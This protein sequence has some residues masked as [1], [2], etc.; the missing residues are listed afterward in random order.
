MIALFS[1]ALALAGA[2]ATQDAEQAEQTDAERRV[3]VVQVQQLYESYPGTERFNQQVQAIQQEFAQAQQAE[4]TDAE[5]RVGVVQVQQ[6]YESYPGTERF[7]Q[8]VQAIQQEFAQAQQAGDQ[9][10]LQELQ[11]RYAQL[12]QE[13]SANFQS[14][15]REASRTLAQERQ[16]KLIVSEVI[17]QDDG[18][19][20]V[21]LTGDMIEAVSE[22]A[23]Q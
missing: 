3:G 18:F 6:L 21:D 13:L 12:Q 20:E 5:R 23:E 11:G 17:Y 7:N 15:L 2:A 22:I 19:E 1:A 9:Q 16:V 10:R 8:Q 14:D 4:H